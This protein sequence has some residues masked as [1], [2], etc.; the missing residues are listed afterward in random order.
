MVWLFLSGQ[1]LDPA[2]LE[3][4]RWPWNG[5]ASIT[6]VAIT[7]IVVIGFVVWD[8]IDGFIKAAR[9]HGGSALGYA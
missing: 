1:L 6:I 3:A 4:I 7:V 9:K 8:M 2:F 5:E